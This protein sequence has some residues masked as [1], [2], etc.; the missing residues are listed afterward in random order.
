MR[1]NLTHGLS[2][3]ALGLTLSVGAKGAHAEEPP[4]PALTKAPVVK[5]FVDAVYPRVARRDRVE[6][7]VVLELDISATGTVEAARVVRSSTTAASA[8]FGLEEGSFSESSTVTDYG[9][10]PAATKAA[11]Q[12]LFEPAEAEG[13]PVPVR[14]AYTV[15]F[16]LPKPSAP[17]AAQEPGTDAKAPKPS[18]RLRGVVRERGTRKRLAGALVTVFRKDGAQTQG[19]EATTDADG[20]FLFYDLQ[21]GPWKLLIE[22]D[23]YYPFRTTELIRF[24]E[25]LDVVYFAEK[26]SYNPYDILV[27]ASRPR[28]EVNRRTLRTADILTVPGTLGDPVLVVEN[29]PGVARPQPGSGQIIVRGSGPEDTGIFIEGINVPLIYHFGGIR[30]VVPGNIIESIDFYPGNFS[31]YYGRAIG[32]ILDATFRRL[33]PDQIHGIVDVSLLDASLQVEIPLGEDAA[34]LIAGRRS[35][36]DAI[37]NAAVSDDA[38]VGLVTAPR[39]YDYQLLAQWRPSAAHELRLFVLG[40]DDKLELLFQDP[41]DIDTQLQTGNLEAKTNFQ[42]LMLVHSY[43]PNEKLKHDFRLGVGRDI[44]ESSFGDQFRF[45]LDNLQF[46]ARQQLSMNFSD[47]LRFRAGVDAQL[48]ITDVEVLA[49]RPP[50]EGQDTVNADL[51]DTLFTK[52]ENVVTFLAAP[53]VEGDIQI[54]RLTLTPGFRIDYFERLGELSLDPRVVVRYAFN[55]IWAAKAG[56]GL[57]HQAP[58]PQETDEV[59]GNPDLGPEEAIQTSVGVEWRPRPHLMIDA[60]VFYKDMNNMV[61]GVGTTTERDGQIVPLVYDN[62]GTGRVYGLELFAEHKF[63]NNFRGW[64]SYTLSRA[65]RVDSG[66]TSSRLFDFDQTHILA[67]VASYTFPA[68]WE[69]GF[70]W[71]V[72]SG[73]PDTPITGSTFVSDFDRHEPVLGAVNSNRLP[74]FHQLD[75]R[76]DK[77]WIYDRWTLSAY[78]SLTN[79]YNRPNTEALNYNFDFS[80]SEPV[81]GLP[82]FPIL[83]I[84]AEL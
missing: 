66:E 78:L 67:M 39:Y 75:I 65:E 83:G 23:G 60:T 5:T 9:F 35:Y 17:K 52:L 54:G 58:T 49:P 69:L 8:S 10:E 44:I 45:N 77:R 24:G 80:D 57:S 3:L 13:Q 72:V 6:A 1:P 41:A 59:F 27:E 14:I 71:R 61:S 29:L 84:K 76:L 37:L 19:F 56:V 43:A 30:S 31:V 63:T 64:L 47:N 20:N 55:D 70:R 28:K 15:R 50:G 25:A 51:R 38:S 74:L 46:Q 33:K 36:V 34:I 82:I 40:S 11:L 12:M 4:L 42:R 32:G 68:N 21:E 16:Q 22:L 79:A 7:V 53:F 73:N 2:L 81:S 48:S 62:G 18:V 26:G